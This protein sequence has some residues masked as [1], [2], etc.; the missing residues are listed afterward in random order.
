LLGQ[1]KK[2]TVELHQPDAD[3]L[4]TVEVEADQAPKD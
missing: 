1:G 2:G 3:N 4:F